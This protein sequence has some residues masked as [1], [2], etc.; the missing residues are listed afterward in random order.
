MLD[1]SSYLSTEPTVKSPTAKDASFNLNWRTA[2]L[3]DASTDGNAVPEGKN[4]NHGGHPIRAGKYMEINV[5]TPENAHPLNKYT[6]QAGA[7]HPGIP[8]YIAKL[9]EAVRETAEAGDGILMIAE[10]SSAIDLSQKPT[11]ATVNEVR[12]IHMQTIGLT[13]DPLSQ[14]NDLITK[15]IVRITKDSEKKPTHITLPAATD[16]KAARKWVEV[17]FGSRYDTG[18]ELIATSQIGANIVTGA[19]GEPRNA[20][21]AT[22]L[23]VINGDGSISHITDPEE[24]D[25]Y[26]GTQGYAG[27]IAEVEMEIA[28]VPPHQESIVLPIP[29]DIN[30]GYSNILPQIIASLYE[31]MYFDNAH[32]H[33]IRIEAV[34][35][36]DVT[37]CDTILR[38]TGG[39]GEAARL[40]NNFKNHHLS[41]G[42]NG[43]ICLRVRHDVKEGSLAGGFQA[44]HEGATRFMT[45]ICELQEAGLI[46]DPEFADNP[47]RVAELLALRT[48]ITEE[49]RT[50]GS[51]TENST[52]SMDE[53]IVFDLGELEPTNEAKIDETRTYV[54]QAMAAT[55][56][57]SMEAY[58]RANNNQLHH[59]FYGHLRIG[60]ESKQ[61]RSGAINLHDRVSGPGSEAALIKEIEETRSAAVRNLDRRM[62]GPVTLR[63]REGEKHNPHKKASLQKAVQNN[64]E[65]IARRAQ[66]IERGGN[67][68][69]YRQTAAY[70]AVMRETRKR[71]DAAA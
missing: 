42:C 10:E 17:L 54:Q 44:D 35:F 3:D 28:E 1:G 50:E 41:N 70:R 48:S 37:G 62:F 45:A 69:G 18:I 6:D 65:R 20:I 8:A 61:A 4:R 9:A 19:R 30:N 58:L 26:Y 5:V 56:A 40:A 15:G 22:K 16:P 14:V 57:P 11:D 31:Y 24:I 67:T 59:T 27:L 43:A 23:T 32:G 12:A 21:P 51:K 29:G 55:L 34:E 39:A 53:E 7:F 64:P 49:A 68:F 33:G 38:N 46:G 47:A 25:A 60:H 36:M 13:D 52:T 71:L 2:T 63:W 66:I